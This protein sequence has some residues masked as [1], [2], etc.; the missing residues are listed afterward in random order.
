M[1]TGRKSGFQERAY[2]SGDGLTLSYRDYGTAYSEHLPIVCLPGM[3]RNAR[4]FDDLAT[5]LST[6]HR[7]L[8]P[9]I[10]GRG[11]SEHA[12]DPTSYVHPVYIDDLV[13]LCDHANVQNMVLIGTSFGGALA[14]RFA[15]HKLSR[16]KGLVLN[17]IGPT[18]SGAQPNAIRKFLR[19]PE[20]SKTWEAAAMQCKAKYQDAYP[21]WK[22]DDWLSMARR[23]YRENRSGN[24]IPDFDPNIAVPYE[25]GTATDNSDLWTIYKACRG[26][27]KLILRGALSR[28]LTAAQCDEM[29]QNS[30]STKTQV[31][32][33]VGHAPTLS[34]PQALSAI[35]RFL[36]DCNK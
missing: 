1:K 7:F 3:T 36:K 23:Q 31:I 16:V 18:S 30:A 17:D 11:Q 10:R 9:D 22:A 15:Q 20:T 19:S 25:N 29:A 33:N 12:T 4:D 13:A 14:L 21:L 32:K 8:C 24:I 35:L 27:P 5:R 34:E 6:D 26:I 2:Q 28:N